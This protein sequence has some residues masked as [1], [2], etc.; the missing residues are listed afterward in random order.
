MVEIRIQP[1]YHKKSDVMDIKINKRNV[2]FE[3]IIDHSG[4]Q[5]K[6]DRDSLKQILR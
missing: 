6:I 4:N 3:V 1:K 5:F 2:V